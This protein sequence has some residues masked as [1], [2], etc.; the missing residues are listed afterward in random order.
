MKKKSR[1]NS[2]KQ[3]A[4]DVIERFQNLRLLNLPPWGKW[5]AAGLA[6]SCSIQPIYQITA[7]TTRYLLGIFHLSYLNPNNVVGVGVGIMGAAGTSYAIFE[8]VRLLPW[9]LKKKRLLASLSFWGISTAAVLSAGLGTLSLSLLLVPKISLKLA[10]VFSV[11]TAGLVA[12]ALVESQWLTWDRVL[13]GRKLRKF[14]NK[15]P[16]EKLGRRSLPWG[17]LQVQ[18]NQESLSYLI[19]GAPG[20]GKSTW[21]EVLMTVSLAGIGIFPNHRGLIVDSKPDQSAGIIP[22][23]EALGIPYKILNPLDYRCC[24]WAIGRDI[25]SETSAAEFATVLIPESEDQKDNKYFIDSAR[26]LITAIVVALQKVKGT[27]WKLRDLTLACSNKADMIALLQEYHPRYQAYSEFF[28]EKKGQKN[29]VLTTIQANLLPL[30]VI[31]ARWEHAQELIS[32][33]DWLKAEYVLIMGSDFEFPETLKRINQLLFRFIAAGLKGMPD[34]PDRRVWMF[35]DELAALGSLP[36]LE[37]VLA[38]GRSKSICTFLSTQNI[39]A[40]LR[41]VG[42]EKTH[43]ILGLCR[44][45]A[46]MGIDP[47]TAKFLSEYFSDYEYIEVTDSTSVSYGPKDS[48]STYGTQS[49]VG[50]RRTVTAQELM[51]IN[52]ASPGP[53]NGLSA[54]FTAPGQGMHF[55]RYDWDEIE[56]MRVKRVDYVE[57]Y[58]RIDDDDST[59]TLQPWSDAERKALGLPLPE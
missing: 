26:L 43:E 48:T 53:E 37:D 39:P 17:K 28:K 6:V 16:S 36:Q 19:L 57:A 8:G 1:S 51:D 32:I 5:I 27:A 7:S 15:L 56:S 58:D 38:L 14:T 22:F 54:Y 50:N 3:E 49:K 18:K 59:A 24:G 11:F 2:L 34:D 33:R 25:R 42:R 20:M 12:A 10:F 9:L 44:W 41:I 4:P 30:N 35:I 47:E 31:A 45:K 46:I 21:L 52:I 13:R 23:L 55:H 40:L 29:E